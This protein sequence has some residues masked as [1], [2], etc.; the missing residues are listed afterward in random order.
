MH[1]MVCF[2]MLAALLFAAEA[3][4]R[5]ITIAN[6]DIDNLDI[7]ELYVSD[8]NSDGWGDDLLDST[9]SKNEDVKVD[10]RSEGFDIHVVWEDG[11]EDTYKNLG[12]APQNSM[13]LL[14]RNQIMAGPH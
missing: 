3:E 6:I 1:G 10:V 13:L 2:V 11:T 14:S 12:N 7:V 9:L 8:S 4:A 5:I